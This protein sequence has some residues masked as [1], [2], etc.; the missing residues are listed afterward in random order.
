M[1]RIPRFCLVYLLLSAPAFAQR[2]TVFP[3]FAS[4]G[5]WSCQLFL[6]NQGLSTVSGVTVSFYDDNGASLSVATNLGTRSNFVIDLNAGTTQVIKITAASTLFT[7][8]ITIHYPSGSPV[9]ATE[10]YRYEAGGSVVADVGVPQQEL[11]DHYSFPVEI[12][13]SQGVRSAIALVNTSILNSS[14]LLESTIVVNL[15]NPDG[16]IRKTAAVAM[17]GGQHMAGYLDESWLFPN[18]G[19]F[20]GSVS[21]SSPAGVAVLA[22]RQDKQAFGAISTDSGPLL[23]AFAVTGTNVPEAEPNDSFG[24]AQLIT[25]STVLLG[26]IGSI[27]DVDRYKFTG[28]AG[29][30][31][32]VITQAGEESYL[33][34]TIIGIYDSSQNLIAV[35]DQTGLRSDNNSFIQVALPADGTYYLVLFDYYNGDYYSSNYSYAYRLQVKLP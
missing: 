5:G 23:G 8:Y 31:V 1:K 26:S 15:I 13:A 28:K 11:N 19:D 18:L 9:R 17:K 34:D 3:Q 27:S 4:G 7:G 21:I 32:S 6:A 35:N 16:S 30:I 2:Y 24:N 29:D 20:S 12:N 14:P 33:L 25:G 22:L 10:V